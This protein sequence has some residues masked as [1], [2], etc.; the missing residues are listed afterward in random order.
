MPKCSKCGE[1][2]SEAKVTDGV[3]HN[4]LGTEN[5]TQQTIQESNKEKKT[6]SGKQAIVFTV[7]MLLFVAGIIF[8][9]E[10]KQ[11][12][13]SIVKA[14]AYKYNVGLYNMTSSPN[15][16]EVIDSYKKEGK[17]IQILKI[18]RQICE[19]PM[20]ETNAGWVALGMNCRG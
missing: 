9:S 16:I 13:E 3:C 12:F 14:L 5:N 1:I 20:V 18:G 19:M 17:Y 4:C 8:H 11:K 10:Q 2:V 15:E 6:K 7:V